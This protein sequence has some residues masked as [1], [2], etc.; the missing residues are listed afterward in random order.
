MTRYAVPSIVGAI[1]V[2]VLGVIALMLGNGLVPSRTES[3]E[4]GTY[5]PWLIVW[6]MVWITVVCA[7]VLAVFLFRKG[8]EGMSRR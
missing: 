3:L 1:V 2:A 5:A 7:G 6:M 4:K 8:V